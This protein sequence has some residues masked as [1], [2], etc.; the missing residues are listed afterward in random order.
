MLLGD[1]L[2]E[3]HSLSLCSS[4]PAGFSA[5]L[6]PRLDLVISLVG[7]V[8]SSALALIIPPLLEVVTYYGEGI[9]PL[10]VTKDALISILGFM[11]FVVGTYQALDEL[12]KSGNSPALS[13][14][15]MFIQ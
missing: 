2:F 11:G 10:T 15:T 9:S 7:S 14:S 8:S 13:N 3:A 6:I 1:S 5:V 4:L 12:I